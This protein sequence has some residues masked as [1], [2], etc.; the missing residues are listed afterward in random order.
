MGVM[1]NALVLTLALVSA[2]WHFGIEGGWSAGLYGWNAETGEYTNPNSG[3]RVVASRPAIPPPGF[4]RF[5]FSLE[6]E[7]SIGYTLDFGIHYKNYY[8]DGIIENIPYDHIHGVESMDIDTLI[9]YVH[10]QGA[11]GIQKTLVV[12]NG[13]L[14]I[15]LGVQLTYNYFIPALT[16]SVVDIYAEDLTEELSG[17]IGFI[18]DWVDNP[19]L[20]IKYV[21]EHRMGLRLNFGLMGAIVHSEH[22]NWLA[23]ANLDWNV[24]FG[25]NRNNLIVYPEFGLSTGFR[26]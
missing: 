16:Q 12:G 4:F 26:F 19:Y 10:V 21:D 24:F 11:G 15:P 6:D 1:M 17:N 7:R 14:H 22:F 2:P 3:C 23:G 20:I 25:A 8:V 13:R 5:G 9:P 18:L